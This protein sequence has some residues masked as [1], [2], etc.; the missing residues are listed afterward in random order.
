[1]PTFYHTMLE[2]FLSYRH[3]VVIAYQ[4]N[5]LCKVKITAHSTRTITSVSFIGIWQ[6]EASSM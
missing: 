1:M 6:Q 3:G 2:Q 4:S 5:L